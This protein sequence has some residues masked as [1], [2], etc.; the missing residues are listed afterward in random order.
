MWKAQKLKIFIMF[1]TDRKAQG[2]YKETNE[3][4]ES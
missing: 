3:V 1:W 4:R 2:V